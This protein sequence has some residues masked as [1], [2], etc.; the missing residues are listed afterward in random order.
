MLKITEE[1]YEYY[2]QFHAI[3]WKFMAPL[4][5]FKED[6]EFSPVNVLNGYESQSKSLARRSLQAGI[7]EFVTCVKYMTPAMKLELEE[8]LK[9]EGYPILNKL[10]STIKNTPA[11]ILKRGKIKNLDEYYLI[12]DLL[13]DT[14][15]GL[16]E[17]EV[18]DF[19]KF[20]L[21]FDSRKNK[22]K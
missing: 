9:Q 1:N 21:E 4:W 10:I 8:L 6:I 2:K 19:G 12:T 16:P 11:V 15:N 22:K 17:K 5:G 14:E 7:N 3:T 13:N 18:D 20:L